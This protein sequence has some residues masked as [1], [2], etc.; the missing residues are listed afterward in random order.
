LTV[1]TIARLVASKLERERPR[2]QPSIGNAHAVPA[3]CSLLC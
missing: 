2:A 3:R 1:D